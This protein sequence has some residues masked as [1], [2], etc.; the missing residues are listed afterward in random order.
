M[1]V[2]C[3]NNIWHVVVMPCMCMCMCVLCIISDMR[4]CVF[5]PLPKARKLRTGTPAD[6]GRQRTQLKP[7]HNV[8]ICQ[9][10]VSMSL[11]ACLQ[12]GGRCQSVTRNGFRF[13]TGPSLMLFIHAYY[14]V[15]AP[16]HSQA[17]QVYIYIVAV[18]CCSIQH[19][20][21]EAGVDAKLS[22]KP[23][24]V[25]LQAVALSGVCAA[26]VESAGVRGAGH[27]AA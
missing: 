16:Y 6:H 12:V 22:R 4:R 3:Q 25:H 11:H 7:W 23:V 10:C 19:T 17:M 27:A 8:A 5:I 18:E 21:I 26:V 9:A 14:Q 24:L 20:S 13:D 2:L 15:R 1:P